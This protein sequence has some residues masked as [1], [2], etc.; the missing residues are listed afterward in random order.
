MPW[1]AARRAA[2][3][4]NRLPTILSRVCTSG[5]YTKRHFLGL[6]PERARLGRAPIHSR[7]SRVREKERAMRATANLLSI[8]CIQQR[9]SGWYYQLDNERDGSGLRFM[10]R[11]DERGQ[12]GENLP[13]A[14]RSEISP[15]D[16]ERSC[17]LI[18]RNSGVF[19]LGRCPRSLRTRAYIHHHN[20]QRIFF[21]SR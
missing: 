16:G 17:Q 19:P 1:R 3:L 21:A 14:V 5:V 7:V 15:R 8:K 6:N 4:P 11:G 10:G 20:R 9:N 18:E 12:W 13:D 2:L